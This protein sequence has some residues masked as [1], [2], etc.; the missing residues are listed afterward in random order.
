[1]LLVLKRTVSTH[2]KNGIHTCMF[3]LRNMKKILPQPT[4]TPE[5][6]HFLLFKIN[7]NVS[8]ELVGGFG[9]EPNLHHTCMTLG[10]DEDLIKE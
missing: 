9:L 4:H 5:Q 10:Q 7:V 6:H 8:H 3:W 2:N 1:M